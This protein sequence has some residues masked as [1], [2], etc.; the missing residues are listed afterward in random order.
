MGGCMVTLTLNPILILKVHL[1]RSDKAL[2]GGLTESALTPSASMKSGSDIYAIASCIWKKKGL[3]GFWAGTP[4]GLAQTVPSTVLYFTSFER[5]KSM[6]YGHVGSNHSTLAKLTPGLA[7]GVARTIVV[8]AVAPI[9]LMRTVQTSGIGLSTQQLARNIYK[10]QGIAGFY[11]GWASTVLRDSPFSFI[12]WLGYDQMKRGMKSKGLD[13][14]FPAPMTNFASGS[15]A[16][17]MATVLTHPFDVLK[18]NQQVD[19]LSSV[20]NGK[21]IDVTDTNAHLAKHRPPPRIKT[22]IH[23]GIPSLFRGLSMRLMTIIPGSAL[24]VTVY[25]AVKSASI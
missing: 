8:T 22:L 12:Y 21:K 1:Q 11:R 6:M 17:A 25:E 15:V 19:I 23:G 2:R 4:L 16:A 9:E 13:V 7:G 3:R 14:H 20:E 18:T 5:I 24:M 10:R